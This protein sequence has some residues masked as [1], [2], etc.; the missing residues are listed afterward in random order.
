MIPLALE[1]AARVQAGADREPPEPAPDK[2][3]PKEAAGAEPRELG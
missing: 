3:S 1:A 2:A